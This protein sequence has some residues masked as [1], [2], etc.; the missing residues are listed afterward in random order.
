M[1]RIAGQLVQRLDQ[2][3]EM[4]KTYMYVV[5]RDFGFAPNPFHGVCTLATCKPSIRRNANVGDWVVGMGGR[6]LKAVGHCV[7]AMKVTE[8]LTFDQYWVDLRFQ[9]KKPVRNG[10]TKML[11][12]DNI[13][14]R[15]GDAWLQLDSHHSNSDGS[16]NLINLAKD[17]GANSVLISAKFYYFGLAAVAVPQVILQEMG[18]RNGRSHRTFTDD[19]SRPLIDWVQRG[20]APNRLVSDPF[21]FNTALARYTGIGSKIVSE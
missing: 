7:F 13:Y 14:R 8:K 16:V 21:D 9:D 18:Y 3:A 12:G 17:T 4:S 11:I 19:K 1:A 5:D 20:F 2:F 10:S 6:R 15:E